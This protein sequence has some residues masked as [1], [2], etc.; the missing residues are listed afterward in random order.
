M[1]IDQTYFKL[2]LIAGE[3]RPAI[4]FFIGELDVPRFLP[5]GYEVVSGPHYIA[6][7]GGKFYGDGAVF[8]YP[9]GTHLAEMVA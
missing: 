7:C 8:L 5:N 9:E 4:I 6:I 3:G 2:M 1:N